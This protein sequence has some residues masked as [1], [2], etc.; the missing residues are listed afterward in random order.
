[1]IR[2][3]SAF[4]PHFIDTCQPFSTRTRIRDAARRGAS[5]DAC[6]KR[7]A[8]RFPRITPPGRN[9]PRRR[10]KVH[11]NA[12][13]NPV[14]D[15]AGH[16]A[17]TVRKTRSAT[18]LGAAG[19][20]RRQ[21]QIIWSVDLQRCQNKCSRRVAFETRL[22][23]DSMGQ[24]LSVQDDSTSIYC[25]STGPMNVILFPYSFLSTTFSS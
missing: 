17:S 1:M 20:R 11:L 4:I 7:R 2:P 12:E 10:R 19:P 13:G 6:N 25:L 24:K 9:T 22:S 14:L 8:C 5:K 15:R 23:K 3:I 18:Q 16:Y 21:R